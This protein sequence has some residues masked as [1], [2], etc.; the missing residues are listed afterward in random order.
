MR[1]VEN[2]SKKVNGCGN[3]KVKICGLSRKDDINYVNE[4]QPDYIGFV[5]ASK[6]HRYVTPQRAAGL[7]KLLRWEITPVGVF[8]DETP[9]QV[10]ELLNQGIIEIAQL[11]GQEDETYISR[12][13]Q[14][15]EKPLIQAFRVR[16][17]ADIERAEQSTADYIL[18]DNGAGG[19][20]EAFDWSLLPEIKRPWFLAGGLKPENIAQALDQVIGIK[21]GSTGNVKTTGTAMLYGV[22]VSS[23]V[24]AD[25]RKDY[26]KI[27]KFIS[28]VRAYRK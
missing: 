19:T 15:T 28:T 7:R 24:E 17:K 1:I 27:E 11:H 26:N 22:D 23:G 5:F 25:K 18:L 2:H 8:V 3:L 13:R 20:G 10:A 16:T 9:E 21:P 14:L 6:S 4:L 12:L